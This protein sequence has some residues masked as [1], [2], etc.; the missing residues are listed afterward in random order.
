M[1]HGIQ[2]KPI[3]SADENNELW[4]I[5]IEILKL[6]YVYQFFNFDQEDIL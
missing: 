1:F 4:P 3:I 6:S 5:E 2:Y